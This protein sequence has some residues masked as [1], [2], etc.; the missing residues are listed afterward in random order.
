M[1]EITGLILAIIGI[2]FAFETPRK[3]FLKIIMFKK[4]AEVRHEV[5][6]ISGNSNGSELSTEFHSNETDESKSLSVEPKDIIDKKKYLSEIEFDEYFKSFAGHTV[7]WEGEI[8][9]VSLMKGRQEQ[10]VRIQIVYEERLRGFFDIKVVDFP[11]VKL[12]KS[13]DIAIVTGEIHSPDWPTF[14]LVNPKVLEWTRK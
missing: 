1:I 3:A 11:N 10:E 5:A 7:T 14:N 2:V 12:F 13:G 9:T 4:Q 6:I 8:G